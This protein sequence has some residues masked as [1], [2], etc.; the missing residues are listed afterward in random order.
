MAEKP[1]FYKA[2]QSR[3]LSVFKLT[4]EKNVYKA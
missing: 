1:E 4:N 2:G 3:A